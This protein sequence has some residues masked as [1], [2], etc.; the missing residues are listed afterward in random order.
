MFLLRT[1]EANNFIMY[2]EDFVSFATNDGKLSVNLYIAQNKYNLQSEQSLNDDGY[3]LIELIK[4]KKKILLKI[5]G[6]IQDSLKIKDLPLS[7]APQE[8]T[9]YIGGLPETLRGLVGEYKPFSGGIS[10]L[11]IDNK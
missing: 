6:I 11:I 4:Y 3:Y 5:N 10:D 2:C 1:K 7:I 9:I 8:S